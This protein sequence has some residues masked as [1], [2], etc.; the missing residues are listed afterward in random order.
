MTPT[1]EELVALRD[2]LR[3]IANGNDNDFFRWAEII[4]RHLN[5][6]GEPTSEMM[7]EHLN[8]QIQTLLIENEKLRDEVSYWKHR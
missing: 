6:G 5:N 3:K 7:I 8:K 2:K 1:Q 4:D